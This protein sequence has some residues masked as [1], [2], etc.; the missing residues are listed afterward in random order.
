MA[1]RWRSRSA[2]RFDNIGGDRGTAPSEDSTSTASSTSPN[3]GSPMRPPRGG[4]LPRDAY[5]TPRDISGKHSP[6]RPVLTK[7]GDL[8]E[9]PVAASPGHGLGG[10]VV[11]RLPQ[12]DPIALGIGDPT[13]S[14]YPLHF[15]CLSR[16]VR[17]FGAELCEH[18][19][20]V[21]DPEVEHRLL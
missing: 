16:H 6:N 11:R 15:L 13:E 14:T 21:T 8:E 10:D 17:F 1:G 9:W 20:Q 18:R 19:I 7:L 3:D 12:L 4:S 2:S 5:R